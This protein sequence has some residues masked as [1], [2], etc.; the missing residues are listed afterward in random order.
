MIDYKSV[1]L[2]EE[3]L[4]EI[5]KWMDL[6]RKVDE[7]LWLLNRAGKIPFVV[8]G[9]GQ[10]ATQIGMAYAMKEGD[11]SSPYYRDLAFVTFMG[12]SPYDTMLASFGKKMI[13]IPEE[14]KCLPTLVIVKR[15]YYHKVLQ[16]LHKY[17]TQL[18]RISFK[19]DKNQILLRQLSE[20][21]V[22]IKEIFMR[23]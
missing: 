15:A 14:N 10:E 18:G 16:L 22:Q 1:G 19:M 6:G 21:E 4:K 2:S 11:I 13:L 9:Q 8:S 17:H 3:D 7:R 5:Y 12:I 20:R 23:V